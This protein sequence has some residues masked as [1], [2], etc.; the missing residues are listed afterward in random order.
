MATFTGKFDRRIAYKNSN[1]GFTMVYYYELN[2]TAE[3]V[4][5]AA[6]ENNRFIQ[7]IDGVAYAKSVKAVSKT[8]SVSINET[9][10][11][12]DI[13]NKAI[14]DRIASSKNLPLELRDSAM[15]SIT[16]DA[17][18]HSEAV[19]TQ[20]NRDY[21][22]YKAGQSGSK[23]KATSQKKSSTLADDMPDIE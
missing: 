14:R 1:G 21:E 10:H 15:E 23:T 5:Q 13:Y 18:S 12:V 19:I 20:A 17:I 7:V 16:R 22:A 8:V 2:A 4:M 6:G 9:N 11:F 3:E